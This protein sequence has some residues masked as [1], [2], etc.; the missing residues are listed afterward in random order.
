MER[1]LVR[2]CDW[3]RCLLP[4]LSALAQTI[5][6]SIYLRILRR[7][8][9]FVCVWVSVC[10]RLLCAF[11][12]SVSI[13]SFVSIG[14]AH[15]KACV[16]AMG[17]GVDWRVREL[18]VISFPLSPRGDSADRT[19][20]GSQLQP[21]ITPTARPSP[22]W[23]LTLGEEISRGRQRCVYEWCVMGKRGWSS[24]GMLGWGRAGRELEEKREE[25]VKSDLWRRG[26]GWKANEGRRGEDSRGKSLVNIALFS[27]LNP[28]AEEGRWIH[29]CSKLSVNIRADKFI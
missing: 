6:S 5:C 24:Q 23:S 17:S 18:R 3:A 11:F 7:E 1:G 2:A 9:R 12:F 14:A 16:Q 20:P 29:T 10:R 4:V 28:A 8:K 21:L 26:R 27:T 22:L 13:S 15:V 19:L 25:E